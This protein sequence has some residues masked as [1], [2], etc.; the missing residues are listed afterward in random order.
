MVMLIIICTIIMLKV[1][2]QRE[3]EREIE[4]KAFFRTRHFAACYNV[5]LLALKSFS[6]VVYASLFSEGAL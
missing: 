2:S 3:R 4:R 5:L 1:F 6:D